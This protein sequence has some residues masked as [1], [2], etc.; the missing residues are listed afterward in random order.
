M[1]NNVIKRN[2]TVQ[3]FD[4]E[5]IK[6]AIVKAMDEIGYQRENNDIPNRIANDIEKL[7][8]EEIDIV[9]IEEMI[10]D[11]LMAC[12]CKD[13]ART[14]VRYRYKRELARGLNSSLTERYNKIQELIS[15]SDQETIKENSNKDTRIIPTMRDYLAGFY[16]KEMAEKIV[17]PKHIMDAH[18]DGILHYHDMDYSPLMPMNNCG[19][20]NLEDMLQNG[21]V[22]SGQMIEK[23]HSFKT[24]CT[25]TTQIITQVASSQYGGNS[26]SLSH[27]APFVDISR[28]KIKKEVES[29]MDLVNQC[30]SKYNIDY[31][32]LCEIDKNTTK[33]VDNITEKRLLDEIKDG[34]QTI[35][36]QLITM[37]STNGQSPFTTMFMYLGEI[38]DEDGKR[39]LS[40]II[41]EVLKQRIA[42]IKNEQGFPI[43]VAFPK[44]IYV[45]EEDNIH[46][47]SKYWYLT[48]LSAECSSKRLVPDYI[49]EKKMKE[50]KEGNCFP[51]MG[52]VD[53]EE[54][55]TYKFMGNLFVESFK[56]MWFKMSQHF[57]IKKQNDD[58]NLYIDLDN[59]E[60]FDTKQGFVKCNRIIRNIQSDWVDVNIA[61]GRRLLV[62]ANHPFQTENRGIVFAED[63]TNEDIVAINYNQYSENKI[64]RNKD[65]AWLLGFILCASHENN[66]IKFYTFE[67]K[68]IRKL[69]CSLENVFS[70]KTNIENKKTSLILDLNLTK[71]KDGQNFKFKLDSFLN[72]IFGGK[73]Q[74]DRHIPNEVFSYDEESKYLFLA[75]MIDAHGCVNNFQSTSK[76][77]EIFSKNKELLLQQL[78]LSQTLGM[79]GNIRR[80]MSMAGNTDVLS[81]YPNEKLISYIECQKQLYYE[82]DKS[83]KLGIV[84]KNIRDIKLIKKEMYSYD[85]TTESGHFEVSNVYSHN[86]RSAL[87][88]YKDKNG[89]Y[90]FYGR[91]NQGVVTLNLPYVALSS[92]GDMDKFWNILDERLNL[93]YEAL[94]TRHNSLKGT[95][96]D[97]APILWQY[98]AYA[99]LS[100]G[101]TIDS[102]LYN[103]YSSISLGYAG[104]YEC[105]KYMTNNSHI[106][107]IG[108]EFGIKVMNKLNDTC[109]KWK[110]ETNIGFGL[111]GSPIESTTYK[112]AKCLQKRFGKVKGITDKNYVTNSY[113]ITP[114]ENIN[115]FDKI[116]IESEFQELS[117]GGCI[118]YI[119][120][121][122]MNQNIDA[123]LEVIKYI[124][125]TIMYAEINTTTSY[126]QLC[127]CTDVKMEDDLKFHCPQCGNNDFDKMNISLRICGYVSTNPFNDG[128]AQDIHDRVYHLGME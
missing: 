123:L 63:L 122:N 32:D 99:R 34:V 60:I 46:E 24:A 111:Y 116:K 33:L 22:I 15:G 47:D 54:I 10:E 105:V 117:L 85:V 31:K 7:D 89:K 106:N 88:P 12:K 101:E 102:M 21:T 98:G 28:Q 120:T 52:C 2:K 55:I 72:D 61:G 108:K 14:F 65:L 13:V 29:E 78:A 68:I 126:C 50:L 82:V 87:Q 112:F 40:L 90:K 57:E 91:F 6:I 67:N 27:L 11:K 97:V 109:V 125:D 53:G 84:N 4:K 79:N 115:A 42:G 128:R 121:P 83:D 71:Q 94:M 113:H 9:K 74:I 69:I 20:I 107:P 103:D 66:I 25:I 118:S 114:S 41:E 39:D 76:I 70:I 26:F 58:K 95:K 51:V 80:Y 119:E 18:N 23:P 100:Q 48:K 37:S 8:A 77:I 127:S 75:G 124:Y 45:L 73:N 44:L 56:R 43:T 35:Q 93:C 1:I 5:K 16:C 62:T 110:K 86:C 17:I 104:L 38:Q 30:Y 49:S 19:L 59:T 64:K 36:Y 3:P 81:F 92:N 96:S